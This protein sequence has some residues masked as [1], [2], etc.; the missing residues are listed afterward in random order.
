M[1]GYV[2]QLLLG[3]F[4]KKMFWPPSLGKSLKGA[5]S[6]KAFNECQVR[7]TNHELPSNTKTAPQLSTRNAP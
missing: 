6:F 7:E 1:Y 4:V 5:H 3:M 2:G